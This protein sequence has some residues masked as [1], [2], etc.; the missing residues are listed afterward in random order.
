MDKFIC[1]CCGY[2]YDPEYGEHEQ[3]IEVGTEWESIEHSYRCPIC[4]SNKS[5]FVKM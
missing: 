5:S 4:Q 3:G 1:D 2:I